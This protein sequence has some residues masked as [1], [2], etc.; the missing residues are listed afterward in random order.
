M[1]GTNPTAI[2][3]GRAHREQVEPPSVAVEPRLRLRVMGSIITRTHWEFPTIPYF[4]DPVISPRT[5]AVLS[6]PL[7]KARSSGASAACSVHTAPPHPQNPLMSTLNPA[8][9]NTFSPNAFS[10]VERG[11][12]V[13]TLTLSS[14]APVSRVHCGSREGG[15]LLLSVPLPVPPSTPPAPEPRKRALTSVS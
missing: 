2:G 1:A 3:P 5:C 4:C 13:C 14:S 7:S 11:W 6:P 10:A 12:S 8:S 9:P 15:L